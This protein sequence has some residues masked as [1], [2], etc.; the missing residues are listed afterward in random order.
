MLF[1]IVGRVDS[2]TAKM[3]AAKGAIA[4]I[5][6]ICDQQLKDGHDSEHGK[7]TK[8]DLN[9]FL[10]ICNALCYVDFGNNHD[11]FK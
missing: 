10:S 2:D 11:G 4:K 1:N 8:Q 5:K 6:T 9:N 3:T 7:E